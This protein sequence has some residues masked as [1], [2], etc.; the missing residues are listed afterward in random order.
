MPLKITHIQG[1]TREFER[2]GIYPNYLFFYLTDTRQKWRV[3]IKQ[4]PQEGSLKSKGKVV[5]EY[6]FDENFCKYR[7][8]GDDGSFSEW[9]EDEG[10]VTQMWD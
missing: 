5:F 6:T 4:S 8:V 10:M 1:G 7:E 2:T 3:N 9:L